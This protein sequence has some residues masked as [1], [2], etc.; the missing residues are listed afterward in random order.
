MIDV[1]RDA[2]GSVRELQ[3]EQL[4]AKD[5]LPANVI[6]GSLDPRGTVGAMSSSALGALCEGKFGDDGCSDERGATD[7]LE[8]C[9]RGCGGRRRCAS[10][11]GPIATVTV[12]TSTY[13]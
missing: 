4:L 12:L 9:V 7:V 1:G 5:D 8:A 3:E 2:A 6:C 11:E 10:G 13:E